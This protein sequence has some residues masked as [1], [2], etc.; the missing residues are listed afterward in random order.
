MAVYHFEGTFG[1]D[2]ALCVRPIQE[3]APTTV[4]M[5]TPKVEYMSDGSIYVYTS[6]HVSDKGGRII[7]TVDGPQGN[8][9]YADNSNLTFL[10]F[11]QRDTLL[12]NVHEADKMYT[13]E[14]ALQMSRLAINV[15]RP[16]PTPAFVMADANNKWLWGVTKDE[17]IY[18]VNFVDMGA[19]EY[20]PVPMPTGCRAQALVVIQDSAHILSVTSDGAMRIHQFVTEHSGKI[21]QVRQ[22]TIKGTQPTAETHL[23]V[24]GKGCFVAMF[25]APN[26]ERTM[27]FM[28]NRNNKMFMIE[29]P[30]NVVSN[31]SMTQSIRVMSVSMK[32]NLLKLCCTMG[33]TIYG[34]LDYNMDTYT[35]QN[36][37][38]NKL[39]P[40]Y[41]VILINSLCL[42]DYRHDK[43]NV[44]PTQ[45]VSVKVMDTFLS[46]QQRSM[47]A[48]ARTARN[49]VSHELG[50][51]F[52]TGLIA[53]L[54]ADH[55]TAISELSDSHVGV[56]CNMKQNYEAQLKDMQA[57]HAIMNLQHFEQLETMQ[58]ERDK[59]VAERDKRPTAKALAGLR[60]ENNAQRGQLR[61]LQ[62]LQTSYLSDLDQVRAELREYKVI[63]AK[64]ERQQQD[65]FELELHTL[66]K[67]LDTLRRKEVTAQT[68][69]LE[70]AHK[71]NMAAA[72]ATLE[73]KHSQ[74]M[75]RTIKLMTDNH[76]TA[77]EQAV[78][79]AKKSALED[80]MQQLCQQQQPVVVRDAQA[81]LTAVPDDLLAR[82]ENL[83]STNKA[84]TMRVFELQNTKATAFDKLNAEIGTLRRAN[85]VLSQNMQIMASVGHF[86]FLPNGTSLETALESM[87]QLMVFQE[88]NEKLRAELFKLQQ[89]QLMATRPVEQK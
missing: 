40:P 85:S 86:N 3:A 17:L 38:L 9:F 63:V 19:T 11:T 39:S 49:A 89:A 29:T 15:W 5:A 47:D 37:S 20:A 73:T 36:T 27:L 18:V 80:A 66:R 84:L 78:L 7:T 44:E 1:S 4:N 69:K 53:K 52:T 65:H 71:H 16:I 57:K 67:E 54:R 88:D 28:A 76:Q 75:A 82:L 21:V 72:L 68:S 13:A 83:E 24:H 81:P 55:N 51:T 70:L 77:L 74:A 60:D 61:A 31:K 50:S 48:L 26:N 46:A 14:L 62:S 23:V 30:L 25:N 42:L 2:H 45:L 12:L 59:A 22:Y 10:R 58:A 87:K 32:D 34:H 41:D 8:L 33:S 43:V 35:V 64:K 6:Q 79:A 56:V